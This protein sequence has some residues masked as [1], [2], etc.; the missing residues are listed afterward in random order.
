M[1]GQGGGGYGYAPRGRGRGG[2][3]GGGYSGGTHQGRSGPLRPGYTD[4]DRPLRDPTNTV[5]AGNL[6]P[7]IHTEEVLRQ[8]FSHFGLVM[9]IAKHMEQSYCFIHFRY[10][11]EA[12]RAVQSLRENNTLGNVK[13]NYGKM[14]EYSEEEM[15]D[16]YVPPDPTA[17]RRHPRDDGSGPGGYYNNNNNYNNN[18]DGGANAY[19]PPQRRTRQENVMEPS[20]VLWVGSLPSFISDDRLR[21]IFS[22]FGHVKV[23]SRMEMRNM[24]FVH[25]NT[26][27][28]CTLALETMRGKPVDHNVVLSLN[29]GHP[30]RPRNEEMNAGGGAAGGAVDGVP[31]NE[32]PTNVVYLGQLSPNT[33]EEDV[34]N[35][36]EPFEGFINAKLVTPSGIA[37]G[38]FD[39]VEHATSTRL[40]LASTTLNGVPIR[41]S[42][43]KNNHALTMADKNS[44]N[45]G[46]GMSALDLDELMRDPTAASGALTTFQGGN[47]QLV[48]PTMNG[49]GGQEQESHQHHNN[50]R[51][52][53]NSL[54]ERAAP[55]LNLR[56]R[57]QSV[58]GSTYNGCGALG[59]QLSP[60]Q[61]QAICFVVDECV[62][63]V[64]Q[65]QMETT[66]RL[67]LPAKGVHV[68]NVITKRLRE[69]YIADP[70][71]KLLVFYS[72]TKVLLASA[73]AAPNHYNSAALNAYLMILLT[74][75]E[76]QSRE[77][78]DRLV[79]IMDNLLHHAFL[80][81]HSN[82]T[83]EYKETFRVQLN[84]IRA[85]AEAE[86]DLSSLLSQRR[87]K[88]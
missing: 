17:G 40:A 28:E 65:A 54:R 50:N 48:L 44:N 83:E 32:I 10:V 64:H 22:S 67:Y 30:Q 41:V 42:F 23:V 7:D 24:A 16:D 51:S 2:R 71:R 36:F 56:A 81:K 38:H 88:A 58:M 31:S 52:G 47:Q 15:R 80:E 1:Y 86:Q 73:A 53:A 75:S 46:G 8:T 14:F 25:F 63:A 70:I 13:Y 72:V 68:F 76:Q 19:Q 6:D 11:E 29:Y 20:N 61:I 26:V 78:L 66:L 69:Y 27:E 39:T 43:G 9:R 34:N 21:E 18:S 82:V 85:S 5:W 3:G 12:S 55:E 74:T 87:R 4:E 79:I 84:E 33:T 49:A 37:F 35:L 45:S 60:S 59:S 62:D 57:L 77:G